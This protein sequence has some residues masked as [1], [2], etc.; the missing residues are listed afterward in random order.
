MIELRD[1]C[2]FGTHFWKSFLSYTKTGMSFSVLPQDTSSD[3]QSRPPVFLNDFGVS[4][5]GM[6]TL[7]N[8]SSHSELFGFFVL[9]KISS[10]S[11]RKIIIHQYSPSR[12][13]HSFAS[14]KSHFVRLF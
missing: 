9:L 14:C 12:R 13:C 11:F 3:Q 6:D 5:F 8:I 1:A 4:E 2:A 7:V 10:H